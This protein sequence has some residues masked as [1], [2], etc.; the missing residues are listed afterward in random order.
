MSVREAVVRCAREQLNDEYKWAT[1]GPDTFD[2]SG[3]LAY[4]YGQAGVSISRSSYQQAALGVSVPRSQAQPGDI[5]IYGNGSHVG[6]VT[7]ANEAIHALNE[8]LD[9]RVTKIDGA[10]IGLPLTD[11]RS[12]LDDAPSPTP[13]TP[14]KVQKPRDRQKKREQ[15]RTRRRRRKA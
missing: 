11:V 4:C 7:G 12:I 1:A 5:L 8:D 6:M 13:E 2:C 10:N 3:L 9:I 15:D 14:P